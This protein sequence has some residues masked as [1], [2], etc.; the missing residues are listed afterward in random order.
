M[1]NKLVKRKETEYTFDDSK[2]TNR[3]D[4]IKEGYL[5]RHGTFN[6]NRLVRVVLLNDNDILCLYVYSN[7][8]NIK[9]EIQYCLK[10][11]KCN[12]IKIKQNKKQHYFKIN[13]SDK[14][15]KLYAD[16]KKYIDDWVQII[17]THACK[18]NQCD[19]ETKMNESEQKSVFNETKL[20]EWVPMMSPQMQNA[21]V[22]PMNNGEYIDDRIS[23]PL[24]NVNEILNNIGCLEMYFP[25]MPTPQRRGT[26]VLLNA[27]KY[28]N[29]YKCNIQYGLT[30]AHNVIYISPVNGLETE[31][32]Y[33]KFEIRSNIADHKSKVIHEFEVINREIYPKYYDNPKEYSGYDI[34]LIEIKDKNNILKNIKHIPIKRINTKHTNIA[35]IIGYPGS[36]KN[37]ITTNWLY[38]M[39]GK[40]KI[41]KKQTLLDYSD[42]NTSMGQSG[43]PV[44]NISDNENTI[45]NIY[46]NW[47]N[48]TIIG[49]HTGGDSCENWGTNINKDIIDWIFSKI[50][51]ESQ[52]NIFKSIDE[53]PQKQKKSRYLD[54]QFTQDINTSNLMKELDMSNF[55]INETYEYEFT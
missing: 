23:A 32:E 34:A 38:G 11:F 41:Q 4:I 55:N 36:Y 28:S 16:K 50:P 8:K 39:T 2:D 10:T 42:I 29:E 54:M 21:E 19:R 45:N 15:L 43:S 9:P 7:N 17:C 6:S 12:N 52:K 14:I 49:I 40:Y 44:F 31:S 30:A 26:G 51:N 25:N 22:L 20:E 46:N 13:V 3:D 1:F 18:C 33:I 5:F 37:N 48:V 35:K 24:S 53:S 47:S 27:C